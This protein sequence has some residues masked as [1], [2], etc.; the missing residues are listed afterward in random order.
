MTVIVDAHRLQ[1]VEHD[2]ATI[3]AETEAPLEVYAAMLE[4]I[5]RSLGWELG[6]VWELEPDDERLHRVR[7]WHEGEGAPEFE[8][9]SDRI[10]LRPGEGLPGRVLASGEPYWI[11]DAPS[12]PNFPR[13]EAALRAGLTAAFAFPLVSSRGI[14]GV[15]EFL[16]RTRREPDERLLE[17]MRVIGSQAG[18]FVARRRAEAE[19]RE[20][21]SR[22][23]AMLTAALDAIV[24][25]D[26]R[27]RVL[28]WNHAAETIF[29][30]RSDEAIGREMAD[31]I[32]PPSLR[33]AHRTG[34]QRFIDTEHPVILDRRL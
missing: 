32:V 25:M 4:T 34:L 12:D 11:V 23:R 14:V 7:S 21:E 27:G 9:L 29:G 24:T 5:G 22:L 30:Y 33:E 2:V 6:A 19:V 8:S 1:R 20:R 10:A 31:L 28:G 17:S 15:M 18:Q 16:S 3:L 13:A 26:H